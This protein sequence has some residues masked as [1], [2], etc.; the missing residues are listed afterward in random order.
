MRKD[1]KITEKEIERRQ[2]IL[3]ATT[4]FFGQKINEDSFNR[5]TKAIRNNTINTLEGDE[6]YAARLIHTNLTDPIYRAAL[7]EPILNVA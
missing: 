2:T 1:L 6:Q 4:D 7:K 5:I 3:K